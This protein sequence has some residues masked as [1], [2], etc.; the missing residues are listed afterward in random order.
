MEQEKRIRELV[1]KMELVISQESSGSPYYSAVDRIRKGAS[2][3]EVVTDFGLSLPEAKLLHNL[4]SLKQ[5][6]RTY[7]AP[8]DFS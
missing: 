5:G 7:P 8:P 3:Q 2:P 4:Y 6:N 1:E